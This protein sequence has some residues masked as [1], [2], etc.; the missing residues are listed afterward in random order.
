MT[1]LVLP[2]VGYMTVLVLAE[3]AYRYAGGVLISRKIAHVGGGIVTALLPF[4]TDLATALF[5]SVFFVVVLVLSQ[6][7]RLIQSVHESADGLG[8]IYFPIGMGLAALFFWDI[9]AVFSGAALLFAIPDG[10]SGYVGRRFGKNTYSLTGTKT[11]EGSLA[12]FCVALVVFAVWAY[13]FHVVGGIVSGVV[14]MG[15][16]LFLTLLEGSIGDGIDNLFLPIVAGGL[17]LLCI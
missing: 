9:P 12:F 14:G 16:A 6:R 2:L 3:S 15:I 4:V 10:V 8:S 1:E 7:F 11:L 13:S 17:L 5:I